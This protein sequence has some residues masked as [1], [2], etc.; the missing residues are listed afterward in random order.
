MSRRDA[1][2]R[3]IAEFDALHGRGA[4]AR[5]LTIGLLACAVLAGNVALLAAAV[6]P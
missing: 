2:R 5:D 4:A 3:A 1:I 6:A